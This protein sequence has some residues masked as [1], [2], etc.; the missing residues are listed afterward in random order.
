MQGGH[1]YDYYYFDE[2][3]HVT[4]PV[5]WFSSKITQHLVDENSWKSGIRWDKPTSST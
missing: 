4:T 5:H 3:G 2:G 1:N